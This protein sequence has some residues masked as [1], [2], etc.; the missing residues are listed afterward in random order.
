MIIKEGTVLMSNFRH[1]AYS[2]IGTV[3]EWLTG[4]GQMDCR[5][6]PLE[7]NDDLSI[8]FPTEE[9]ERITKEAEIKTDSK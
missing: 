9:N 4:L 1:R 5:Q 7:R 6:Y 3:E 8:Y 2:A